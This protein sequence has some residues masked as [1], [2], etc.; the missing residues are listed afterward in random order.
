[1]LFRSACAVK[2][3]RFTVYSWDFLLTVNSKRLANVFQTSGALAC[4]DKLKCVEGDRLYYRSQ[5]SYGFPNLSLRYDIVLVSE[6]PFPALSVISIVTLYL[7]LE[8]N[9]SP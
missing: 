5:F 6:I 1:M 7:V 3:L 9:F 4:V 8:I 2:A